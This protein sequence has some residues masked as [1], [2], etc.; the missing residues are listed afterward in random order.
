MNKKNIKKLQNNSDLYENLSQEE[1]ECL[2]IVGFE[3]CEYFS[4]IKEKFIKNYSPFGKAIYRIRKDIMDWEIETKEHIY[5][6]KKLLTF[7][8]TEIEK[9]E[10][11][12][13]LS[14]LEKKESEYF[15]KYT[16]KLKNT[17]YGSKKYNQ[18]LKEL[19]PA[20]DHHYK[21]NRHHPEHFKNGIRNMNLIDIIEMFCDWYAATKR[22]EDGDIIKSI[23][24]NKKRFNYNELLEKI[25][26]NTIKEIESDKK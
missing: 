7:F 2:D 14:K 22:H 26:K 8:I 4:Q 9:R 18:Y 11:Q 13:D 23:E 16:S 6:V 5:N 20:L 19:K 10:W 25:F 15:K 17:T 3:N 21:N 24:Y 12:H 1:K